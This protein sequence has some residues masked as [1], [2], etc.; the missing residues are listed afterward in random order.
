VAKA[1]IV[2]ATNEW[3]ETQKPPLPVSEDER[4]GEIPG[5]A[6]FLQRAQVV[7]GCVIGFIYPTVLLIVLT[8]PHRREEI[9]RWES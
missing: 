9:E 2:R 3:K 5:E 8:R 6:T 1:G 4:A 7:G